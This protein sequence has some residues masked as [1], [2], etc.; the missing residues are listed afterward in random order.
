ML[1]SSSS[2]LTA[3][4]GITRADLYNSFISNFEEISLISDFFRGLLSQQGLPSF[5]H[6]VEIGSGPGRILSTFRSFS[7][8]VTGV[9]FDKEYCLAAQKIVNEENLSEVRIVCE[10]F[11][12]YTPDIPIDC[13]AIINGAFYYSESSE[14]LRELLAC[15]YKKLSSGGVLVL[16]GANL[17]YFI[18]NY[19]KG[20][21]FN[22]VKE[23]KN[24]SVER[25]ISHVIDTFNCHWIHKD[26]YQISG[27][28]N[29]TYE[30]SYR[31]LIVTLE[32]I[33]SIL[34]SIGFEILSV[35]KGWKSLVG[36]DSSSKLLITAR[37]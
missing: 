15:C 6:L 24:L 14:Y 16:E 28:I 19:G 5:S 32:H 8:R 9:D 36:E 17:L 34:T 37:R 35:D 12:K 30:E 26:T 7:R 20:F 2:E 25:Q 18:K 11:L 10:N 31:F 23:I 13:L 29:C 3:L 22:T 27:R 1:V 33:L 4:T 21:S